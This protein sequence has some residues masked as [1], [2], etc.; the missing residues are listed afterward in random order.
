[1]PEV[2]R[3]AVAGKMHRHCLSKRVLKVAWGSFVETFQ[4]RGKRQLSMFPRFLV[5]T[6][7]WNMGLFI[8][9]GEWFWRA[10]KS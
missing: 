10:V 7:G 2:Q 5:W 3:K 8:K 1:M 6:P 4:V 9:T